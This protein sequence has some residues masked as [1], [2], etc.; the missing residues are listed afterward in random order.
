MTELSARA[1]FR[2][3]VPIGRRPAGLRVDGS[4]AE[5]GDDG[6]LPD[7]GQMEGRE[8]FAEVRLAWDED[9]LY[10]GLRVENKTNVTSHRQHPHNAEAL[11]LW[12]DTRDVRDAH[13][14]SRFC[15]Q[16]I[17]LPRGG[18]SQRRGAVAWQQPIRRAREASP[19]CQPQQ[20]RVASRCRKDGY[21]LELALPRQVLGGFDPGQNSRL[22]FAYLVTDHEHG[23]QTWSVPG[24]F[25]YQ[26]D[27]STWATVSL[28]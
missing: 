27:P 18:G 11:F 15:H 16:F 8:A 20:L 6:L 17:A 21:S 14:A 25:P 4:L 13:R 26:V 1:F 28:E 7:L 19:I 23:N 9:G 24:R 2:Y 3:D 22:G 12:I 5:W 10:V